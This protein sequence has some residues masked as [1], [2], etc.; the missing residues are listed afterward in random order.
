MGGLKCP[1]PPV[2]DPT[3][4][5]LATNIIGWSEGRRIWTQRKNDSFPKVGFG[6]AL[7]NREAPDNMDA[8]STGIL[9]HLEKKISVP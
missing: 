8:V 4:R 3:L 7:F 9:L 5:S 2:S 1:C 6:D